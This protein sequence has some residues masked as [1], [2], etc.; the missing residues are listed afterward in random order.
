MT[1]VI[2]STPAV[3]T[4]PNCS[5][6]PSRLL[7]SGARR[8]A[9]S[10]V[11]AMRASA[12]TFFT[13]AVST[14]MPMRLHQARAAAQQLRRLQCIRPPALRQAQGERVTGILSLCGDILLYRPRTGAPAVDPQLLQPQRHLFTDLLLGCVALFGRHRLQIVLG[15]L[16]LLHHLPPH[17]LGRRHLPFLAEGLQRRVELGAG[18]HGRR[19]C[20]R[21]GARRPIALRVEPLQREPC[22]LQIDRVTVHPRLCIRDPIV[23]RRQPVGRRAGRRAA[24]ARIDRGGQLRHGVGARRSAQHEMA[25]H[26]PQFPRTHCG[27]VVAPLGQALCR[28]DGPRALGITRFDVGPAVSTGPIVEVEGRHRR[29]CTGTRIISGGRRGLHRERRFEP[30]LTSAHGRHGNRT[31][32]PGHRGDHHGLLPFCAAAVPTIGKYRMTVSDRNPDCL[33][34]HCP[35]APHRAEHAH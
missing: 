9:S 16:H 3:S 20:E 11:I 31:I 5:I 32:C 12:A 13:V 22:R 26:D 7:S 25:G 8:P 18:R 34:P 35:A 23:Q 10:S 15:D 19:R 30:G 17:A 29:G 28:A 27:K 21:P 1:A 33:T 4:S 24:V 2:G 6:Q 14:D